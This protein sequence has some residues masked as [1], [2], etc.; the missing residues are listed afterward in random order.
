MLIQTS[1]R[2]YVKQKNTNSKEKCQNVKL[3]IYFSAGIYFSNKGCY[4]SWIASLQFCYHIE[5][6]W[7][8]TWYE[9]REKCDSY[10]ANLLSIGSK[11]EFE[12]LENAFKN[13]KISSCLHIGLQKNS[14]SSEPSWVDGNVWKFSKLNSS[15]EQNNE[16]ETCVHR[17]LDRLWYYS[18]C[19]AKCGFVCKKYRGKEYTTPSF[20]ICKISV[21]MA[22]VITSKGTFY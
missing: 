5:P 12:F 6:A 7:K 4:G 14:G 11:E 16:T 18:N 1:C 20:K 2:L 15:L 9:A 13:K 8:L 17:A 19:S 10:L 21:E 22:S 3:C